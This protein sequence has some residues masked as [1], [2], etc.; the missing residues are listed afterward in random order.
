MNLFQSN[1]FAFTGPWGVP[2]EMRV[3]ALLLPVFFVA[4]GLMAGMLGSMLF[5]AVLFVVS[6]YLHELGHAW[7]CVVQGVKVERVVLNA[8]GGYCAHDGA[9]TNHQKELIVVMGPLVNLAVWAMSG[10][11][12]AL[13]LPEG[14]SHLLWLVGVVNLGLAVFNLLPMMPRDGAKIVLLVFARVTC[15]QTATRVTG[16]LGLLTGLLWFPAFLY[17]LATYDFVLLFWPPYR[18]HWR[19]MRHGDFGTPY[20]PV[21]QWFW[22]WRRRPEG[23]WDRIPVS[24]PAE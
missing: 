22:Q 10:L 15:E 3:S 19:M 5:V 7:A 12:S 18:L 13:G 6:I 17:C 20:S 23:P 4:I 11:I 1:L 21:R 16:I 9:V 14:V 2:V 8:L 24:A